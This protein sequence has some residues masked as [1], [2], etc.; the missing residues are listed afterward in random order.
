MLLRTVVVCYLGA[1]LAVAGTAVS[2]YKLLQ[3]RH[4]SMDVSALSSPLANPLAALSAPPTE[5]APT[6]AEPPL[7]TLPELRPPTLPRAVA[8]KPRLPRLRAPLG[9][10]SHE[11]PRRSTKPVAA[12]AAQYRP[13]PRPVRYRLYYR[14]YYPYGYYA[15]YPAYPY[16]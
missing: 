8:A 6:Q 2:A 12:A 11:P 7:F 9:L 5:A 13:H 16:Y 1:T 4:A 3:A 10:A 14:L 15:Y